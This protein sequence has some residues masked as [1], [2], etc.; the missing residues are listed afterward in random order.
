MI[1]SVT[2]VLCNQPLEFDMKKFVH[3]H[4]N[5]VKQATFFST[6]RK[7]RNLKLWMAKPTEEEKS[8]YKHD[9]NV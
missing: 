2:N 8:K 7:P 1:A 5:T 9:E 4:Q 3:S 6:K